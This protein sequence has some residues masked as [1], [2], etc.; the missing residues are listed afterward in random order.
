MQ[1]GRALVEL[2]ISANISV[3]LRDKATS[4][5]KPANIEAFIGWT[6]RAF[7]PIGGLAHRAALTQRNTQA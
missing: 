3:K 6:N 4:D 2:V 1:D 7:S 5:P